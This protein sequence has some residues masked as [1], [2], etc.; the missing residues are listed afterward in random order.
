MDVVG[1]NYPPPP[2]AESIHRATYLGAIAL[3]IFTFAGGERHLHRFGASPRLVDF[4][5]NNK[6]QIVML[7]Y[8]ANTFAANLLQ[9]GAFEIYYDGAQIFSKLEAGRMPTIQVL[10]DAFKQRGLVEIGA[11]AY[12]AS[13]SI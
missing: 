8:L 4:F 12:S 13:S 1:E 7:A 2:L 3:L 11:S 5:A 6:M 9:T 10:H